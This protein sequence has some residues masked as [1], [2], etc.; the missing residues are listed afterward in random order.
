MKAE[1][2]A[3]EFELQE[4]VERQRRAILPP[5][6]RPSAKWCTGAACGE[7]IPDARR[8]A[9]PGVRLCAEC[10]NFNEKYGS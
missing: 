3:Q 9:V 4:W 2:Q 7:R 10:Q 1:D 6:T 8:Q 5:P